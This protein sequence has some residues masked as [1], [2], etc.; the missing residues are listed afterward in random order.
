MTQSQEPIS[1]GVIGHLL[2][3]PYQFDFF[4]AVRLLE[5]MSPDREPVGHN[6]LPDREVVRFGAHASLEFPA[7]QIHDIT[8]PTV[9][10]A[11]KLRP[12]FMCVAFF[13]MHGPLGA[14]P[15]HYTEIVIE[16]LA[17]KDRV[18]L[19]FF[20]L[21]NHRLL[22]LFY[23]AWEKYQFWI[24]SERAMMRE[25]SATANGGEQLRSFV[26]KDRKSLDPVGQILLDLAGLG[27]TAARYHLSERDE[28]KSRT[29][30]SD[31]TWRFYAGL[32]SQRHRPA[33]SLEGMLC[34]YFGFTVRVKPLCG[35]W[36]QLEDQDRTRL[37]RGWNT[38]LG[39]ETVAGKKVWEVQ[40]KFRLSIG[41]L[42]YEQFCSLLPIGTAHHSLLQ[43]TRFYAGQF[44]DFDLEAH[45]LSSEVPELRCGDRKG[46]GPR[47]GWNTWL[48]TRGFP[49]PTVSVVFPT[50][51]AIE[52]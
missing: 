19:E 9:K 52:K 14:L 16:R 8:R 20:D 31:Q 21:F 4:Q 2:S 33:A 29:G 32:L 37:T 43:M 49:A 3:K 6:T 35:R 22:S 46:I 25:A 26:L 42:N 40:S 28:L 23:R 27:Q 5:L 51:D 15:Q 10:A 12:P 41:P 18:L 34:D 50:A 7:S 30:I 11:G 47:L 1:S 44:L 45:L 24:S 17:K 39:K 48:K 36:L 38:A 13:G